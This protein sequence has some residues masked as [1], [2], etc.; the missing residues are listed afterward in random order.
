MTHAP[1]RSRVPLWLLYALPLAG[2]WSLY[3]LAFWPGLMSADSLV[4]WQQ[5]LSGRFDDWHPAFHTM[6]IWAVT[7][8]WFSPAAVAVVQI[9]A[10]SAVAGRGFAL[11][12]RAGMP[13]FAFWTVYILF[14]ASP[15]NGMMVIT[16]WKDIPY[17]IALF[18]LTLSVFEAVYTDGASLS[19][20][21]SWLRLGMIGAL[22]ALFRHNGP[23]AAFATIAILILVW[24]RRW[25]P[26]G[27][28]LA[29]SVVL[30]IGV[31][32]PIYEAVGVG[33]SVMNA[34]TSHLFHVAAHISEHTP[35]TDEEMAYVDSL[36]PHDAGWPYS[37]S[38]SN[39]LVHDSHL[40]RALLERTPGKLS[41]L[42][43]ALLQWRPYVTFRHILCKSTLIWR[44][45]RPKDS[46]YYTIHLS[47]PDGRVAPTIDPNHLG[48]EPATIFPRWTALVARWVL[49]SHDSGWSWL[50]WRPAIY[51]YLAL[52]GAL[53]AS[54]RY[55]SRK[56]LLTVLPI[57][58]H[59]LVLGLVI[60]AQ[61]F[62]Y[63]YPVYLVGLFVG[64]GAILWH[65]WELA[66]R[67]V[68]P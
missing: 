53:L 60:P 28:A 18:A 54:R 66:R 58:L 68:R 11:A 5:V 21:M 30:C 35:L 56:H 20:R 13:S 67:A 45:T 50:V 9:L 34:V 49:L 63:Q 46:Y 1:A 22:V 2:I 7:R 25:K 19:R 51:L 12:R 43:W 23:V 36:R 14:S 38:V 47:M 41:S 55:R 59:T 39:A 6:T 32:G 16:L 48:L 52:A 65:G 61:D 26:L 27:A 40:D 64:V 15:V 8:A 33:R 17:S 57:F 24:R 29:V 31:R 4:Q 3:L 37:C 44:L 10:M 42:S 62:R